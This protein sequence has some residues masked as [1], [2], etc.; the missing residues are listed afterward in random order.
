MRLAM[1][2]LECRILNFEYRIKNLNSIFYILYSIFYIPY[3]AE[4]S[5][6]H[7]VWAIPL[8]LATTKGISF[9]FFSLVT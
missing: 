5:E 8:S 9:D 6:A 4:R 2:G 7:K 1:L 3:S